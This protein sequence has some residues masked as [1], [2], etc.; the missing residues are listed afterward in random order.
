M[1]MYKI[2][3]HLHTSHTSKCGYLDAAALA[4]I[5]SASFSA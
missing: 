5:A 4:F 3:T 2:E 1:Q